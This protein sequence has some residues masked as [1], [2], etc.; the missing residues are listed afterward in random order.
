MSVEIF[1]KEKILSRRSLLSGV[2][3][4]IFAAP[5]CVSA[6]FEAEAQERQFTSA[7][8]KPRVERPRSHTRGR[9]RHRRLIG[10]RRSSPHTPAEAPAEK[11]AQ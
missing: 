10:V 3:A 5:L 6:P 1:E 9:R 4:A 11:P 2:L 7:R 8:H